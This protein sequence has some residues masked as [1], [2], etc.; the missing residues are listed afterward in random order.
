MQVI[1][2]AVGDAREVRLDGVLDAVAAPGVRKDLT[3][4]VAN[5]ARALVVDLSE[6]ERI[7]SSGLGALVTVLEA[8]R[9][10]DGE[11]ALVGL[12][13]AVRVVVELTRL[14]RVFAIYDDARTALAELR[15]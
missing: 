5:G 10:H 3:E 15:R 1:S 12:P 9:E 4:L 7:D 14:H 6:V 13:P 2:R 8:I 11:M